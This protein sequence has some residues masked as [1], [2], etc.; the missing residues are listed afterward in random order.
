MSGVIRGGAIPDPSAASRTVAFEGEPHG[1]DVSLFL[2]DNDPGRG[3]EPHRHPY[4]E[5][6][7]VRAGRAVFLLGEQEVE[8][9]AGDIVVVPPDT[10]HGFRNVGE[11][12]LDL[13]C[14][15]AAG[16]ME[17]EWLPERS[18]G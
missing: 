6:F 4:S 14:V 3:A 7:V 10:V 16:R 1:G 15:H 18:G 2:V 13:V 11:G 12:R 5:T 9:Q 17:T 8:A